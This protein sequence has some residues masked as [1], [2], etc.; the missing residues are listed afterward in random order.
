M[1][2]GYQYDALNRLTGIQYPD[3]TLNVTLTYDQGTN[4]IGHLTQMTD[5]SGTSDYAYD[6]RGNL[7]TRTTL[8]D[9]VT[10]STA[11]SYNGSDQPN[12]IVYPSGRTVDYIRD[13]QRRIESVTTTH[14]GST[15]IVVDNLDYEPFGPRS[16]MT[17]GNG[18]GLVRF[19]D[20]DYRLTAQAHSI[21]SDLSYLYDAADNLV[22]Q[23]DN[24]TA[25][26]DQNY[27]YDPLDRLQNAISGSVSREYSYDRNGNRLT[28]SENGAIT[29]YVYAPG[30]HHLESQSGADP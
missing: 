22:A 14:Q 17:F 26:A 7:K 30:T 12:Q 20:L 8:R 25:S 9:G 2:T 18:I 29:D 28:Y 19:F 6:L 5:A 23:T 15:K 27:A 13:N 11:Y 1:T 10:H 3:S 21:V 24:L 4:G 16:A